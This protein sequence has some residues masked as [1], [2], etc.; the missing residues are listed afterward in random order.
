MLEIKHKLT[1]NGY[2]RWGSEVVYKV[3]PVDEHRK[4]MV[5]TRLVGW[6]E[7]VATLASVDWLQR[8]LMTVVDVAISC[9][10]V[11]I[12]DS[13]MA[14]DGCDVTDKRDDQSFLLEREVKRGETTVFLTYDTYPY[15]GERCGFKIGGQIGI[16]QLRVDRSLDITKSVDGANVCRVTRSQSLPTVWNDVGNLGSTDLVRHINCVSVYYEGEGGVYR[17]FQQESGGESCLE[18][19]DVEKESV[20]FRLTGDEYYR[21]KHAN[22][23]ADVT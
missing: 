18:V 2:E 17:I 5:E 9:G 11:K 8:T 1:D 16:T 7:V 6:P 15:E 4:T 3:F 12:G 19:V 14:D 10:H 22:L 13:H 21:W 23:H 20:V